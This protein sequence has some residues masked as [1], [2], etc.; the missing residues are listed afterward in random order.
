MSNV[1]RSS[2]G[3]SCGSLSQSE[4]VQIV[5][6]SHDQS[7]AMNHVTAHDAGS[8]L[9]LLINGFQATQAIHV[10]ATLRLADHLRSGPTTIR[11]LSTATRTNSTALYRLMRALAAIGV[12]QED[13][14][15][16]FAMT[17]LS[18]LL[19][20]DVSG[21][22]APMAELVGRPYYWQAWGNLLH[23]VC[24]GEAAFNHVHGR[25]IWGYR[26]NRPAEARIFDQA[27]AAGTE[28]SADAIIGACDF[29]RFQHV[30]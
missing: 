21:T 14:D 17:A 23:T 24:T 1:S 27:M 25:G 20:S 26:A 16:L 9:N 12:F 22:Y 3:R 29:A 11:E 6:R 28:R 2:G 5:R 15:G 13:E 4:T 7:V 18:E 19:R 8:A 10:V 30:V